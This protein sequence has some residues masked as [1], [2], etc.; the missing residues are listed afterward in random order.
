MLLKMKTASVETPGL[1]RNGGAAE[2]ARMVR[3][4]DEAER[5]DQEEARSGYT[6][7]KALRG[8][9]ALYLSFWRML[10]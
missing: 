10:L 1:A 3:A 8:I 2:R 6:V 4:E 9:S 7:M 5:V